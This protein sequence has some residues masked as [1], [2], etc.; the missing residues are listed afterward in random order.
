MAKRKYEHFA[1]R[2]Y[3]YLREGPQRDAEFLVSLAEKWT[4]L[5]YKLS[6][7][8]RR[9]SFNRL[10]MKAVATHEAGH[11][12]VALCLGCSVKSVDLY[13]ASGAVSG[14]TAFACSLRTAKLNVARLW[15]MLAGEEAEHLCFPHQRAFSVGQGQES[16]RESAMRLGFKCYGADWAALA[17]K[18]RT[19][20]WRL[21]RANEEAITKAATLLVQRGKL[22]KYALLVNVGYKLVMPPAVKRAFNRFV[23]RAAM[24]KRRKVTRG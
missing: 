24:A 14:R 7:R 8:V 10:R 16:D 19:Q 23:D 17:D 5:V 15:I 3:L 12:I 21:I 22:D 6:P 2:A 1:D 13:H 18:M 4:K 9:A 11:A 20:V